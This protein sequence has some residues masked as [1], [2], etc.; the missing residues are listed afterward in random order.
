ML[1]CENINWLN[2][3]PCPTSLGFWGDQVWSISALLAWHR[4][5]KLLRC[6]DSARESWLWNPNHIEKNVYFPVALF[7]IL[8]ATSPLSFLSISARSFQW[9]APRPIYSL[10]KSL[11][12]LKT[13]GSA[14]FIFKHVCTLQTQLGRLNRHSNYDAVSWQNNSRAQ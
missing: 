13:H 3:Y 11:A 6:V 4:Q 14:H 5:S 2:H 9:E 1:A 7:Q 12:F 10:L 8:F